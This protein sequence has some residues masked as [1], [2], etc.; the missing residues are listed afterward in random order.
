MLTITSKKT[1]SKQKKVVWI[2]ARQLPG[3]ITSSFVA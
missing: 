2:L 3:E 1:N